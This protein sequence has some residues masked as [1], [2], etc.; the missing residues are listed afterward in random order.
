MSLCRIWVSPKDEPTIY[1]KLVQYPVLLEG[2]PSNKIY[3]YILPSRSMICDNRVRAPLPPPPPPRTELFLL[4]VFLCGGKGIQLYQIRSQ[5]LCQV[6]H[7]PALQ[8]LPP[9]FKV[10]LQQLHATGVWGDE[11][12]G[13]NVLCGLFKD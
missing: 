6:Q 3:M 7:A 1:I 2:Y 8:G 9:G 11:T 10:Q 4:P 13:L 5:R 12:S